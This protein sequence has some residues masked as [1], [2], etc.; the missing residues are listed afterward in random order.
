MPM[1]V[2]NPRLILPQEHRQGLG[3]GRTFSDGDTESRPGSGTC[4]A[5]SQLKS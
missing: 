3:G 4:H 1:F 2:T 5:R